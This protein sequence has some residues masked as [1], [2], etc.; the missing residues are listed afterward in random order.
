M[1]LITN[2][3]RSA[4]IVAASNVEVLAFGRDEFLMLYKQSS[5]Y[6]DIKKKILMRVKNNFYN[7]KEV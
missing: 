5:L 6:E 1:A 3:A 4:Q 2:E 7:D